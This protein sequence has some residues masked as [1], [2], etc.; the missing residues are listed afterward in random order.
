MAPGYQVDELLLLQKKLAEAEA[1]LGNIP[2]KPG[3]IDDLKRQ[4]DEMQK[5]VDRLSQRNPGE[6]A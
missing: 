5:K 3:D 1:A 4:L 6:P 2:P